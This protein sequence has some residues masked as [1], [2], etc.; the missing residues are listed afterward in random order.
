MR[1]VVER[2]RFFNKEDWK[3][4]KFWVKHFF[5]A[6]QVIILVALTNEMFQASDGLSV[7]ISAGA[8]RDKVCTST[9]A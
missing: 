1:V 3:K 7:V 4:G 8:C 5:V 9:C 2:A 6:Y